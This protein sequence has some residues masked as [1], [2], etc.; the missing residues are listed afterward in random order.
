MNTLFSLFLALLQTGPFMPPQLEEAAM[1]EYPLTTTTTQWVILDL[2]TGRRGN[3][4]GVQ[5]LQGASPFLEIALSNVRQWGFSP[6]AAP[7][8]VESQVTAIFLFRPRDMFLGSPVLLSQIFEAKSD[9]APRPS[10]LSD[11]GYPREFG[12]RRDGDYRDAGR[13]IRQH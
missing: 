3:V 4:Q 2:E 7:A 11:P 13:G 6:A 12:W 1:F 8:P 5:I 9:R 10:A